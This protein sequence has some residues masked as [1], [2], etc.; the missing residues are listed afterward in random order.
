MS[1]RRDSAII[2]I[3]RTFEV[4]NPEGAEVRVGG[5]SL[6]GHGPGSAIAVVAG[7][8]V[9]V[10]MGYPSCRSIHQVVA[11]YAAVYANAEDPASLRTVPRRAIRPVPSVGAGR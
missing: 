8:S 7:S 1:L 3:G 6:R 10:D 2:K 4:V 5:D 9:T 11:G